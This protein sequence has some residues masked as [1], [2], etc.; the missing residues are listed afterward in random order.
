MALAA[1]W[2]WVSVIAAGGEY[3]VVEGPWRF[4]TDPA[5]R[6]LE[7]G[8]HRPDFDDSSWRLIQ[9]GLSWEEQGIADYDGV[10]WYRKAIVIPPEL[11][12]RE[13]ALFFPG[14]DD[15]Y[16][17]YVDGKL[18]ARW[19]NP[20]R[21][22]SV[23]DTETFVKLPR[24]YMGGEEVVVAL[25]VTDWG[26]WGGLRRVPIRLGPVPKIG[27]I[28]L[29]GKW[30]FAT[31]PRDEGLKRGWEKADFDDSG[32]R[33]IKVPE[34]WESQGLA[35][36]NGFAWYRIRVRIPEDWP[37]GEGWLVV[38]GVDDAYEVYA[39]GKL[40]G[41]H[42]SL[43]PAG[44]E[45]SVWQRATVTDLGE[46][47]EPGKEL[48]LAIR[49]SDWG[50][51]G[52]IVRGPVMLVSHRALAGGWLQVIQALASLNPGW[53]LPAWLRG[54]PVV[55]TVAGLARDA[56]EALAGPDGS[57]QPRNVCYS[58]TPCLYDSRAKRALGPEFDFGRG[59][60]VDVQWRLMAG[61]LPIVQWRWASEQGVV[62]ETFFVWK[63]RD[64]APTAYARIRFIPA[65]GRRMVPAV[66]VRP[67]TLN[68]RIVS[69]REVSVRREGERVEVAVDEQP[70]GAIC[71]LRPASIATA[72]LLKSDASGLLGRSGDLGGSGPPGVAITY[73]ETGRACVVDVFMP[74]EPERGL[75]PKAFDE[76]LGECAR[77]W[78]RKLGRVR[79]ELPDRRLFAAALANA[80]YMLISMDGDQPH[81]GPL[82]YDLFWCRDSAYQIAAMLRLG[83]F[84]EARAAASVYPRIQ[85]PDGEYVSIVTSDYQ[86]VG[87]H[88][89]DAQ[90]QGVFSLVEVY[91]FTRDRKWLE[92]VYPSIRRACEF[93]ERIRRQRLR[94]EFRNAPP[95]KGCAF[96]ILPPSVSAEDL[97]PGDW[98]HYWDD[99]W[100][101]RA[102]RDLEYAA[103]ELGLEGDARWAKQQGDAL[104]EAVMRSIRCTMRYYG[105]DYVPDGPEDA[106]SSSMARGTSPAIWPGMVVDPDSELLRRSFDAYWRMW[107]EPTGGG[108]L[109]HGT[110]CGYGMEL[111]ACYAIMGQ[112]QRAWQMLM[113]HLEHQ[114]APG[115]WAWGESF[116]PR[117]GKFRGGDMPHTWVGA[118]YI[119]LL[120]TCLL[121]ERDGAIVLLGGVPESWLRGRR[122]FSARALPT[123]WGALDLRV[124]PAGLSADGAVHVYLS[125]DCRPP[126][127]FRALA[128]AG[129]KV[130]VHSPR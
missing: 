89:W 2:I 91:R 11:A 83:L 77:W 17:A 22:W 20:H 86:P 70:F 10:A 45:K 16:E 59:D 123:Y 106:K 118:D 43:K 129:L 108:Y 95:P 115:V 36:Y 53:V 126:R 5:D 30:R 82:N 26:H 76:A 35:D 125:G 97:G 9:A 116:D 74:V 55:W 109:H 66:M 44:P 4:H 69:A 130:K 50:G 12:G 46:V 41:S 58:L 54:G 90:G 61:Y 37:A 23:W 99:F 79:L 8:W 103:R 19:G 84:E 105:V 38:G 62:T 27:A 68:G 92:A 39:N 63:G 127:G 64:G 100:A 31:D 73:A 98:H 29:V 6:G 111:A 47:V 81:P 121:Y 28:D 13:L 78:R 87:P 120:R 80:A 24:R 14:V 57:I 128:P 101:V 72:G 52:G 124:V 93:L 113:W 110:A 112:R 102:W 42:G 71:G 67:Y 51:G 33:E 49:V 40:V 1:V 104:L 7:L 107:I 75:R 85:R 48:V 88:E 34:R 117:T 32:W 65:P 94:D 3:V 18:C 122:V 15:A 119:N 56:S 25:R 114:S 96:G 21:G 60:Y